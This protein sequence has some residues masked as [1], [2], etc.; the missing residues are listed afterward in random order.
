MESAEFKWE[1]DEF[2]DTFFQEVDKLEELAILTQHHHHHP[3]PPKP[4]SSSA[5]FHQLP[6][7]PPPIIS[8]TSFANNNGGS[9]VIDVSYSPPRELSQRFQP[10]LDTANSNS[11]NTQEQFEIDRL[12]SEL[13]RVS[14]QLSDL[15]E[16]CSE[17][18]RDRDKKKQ[19]KCVSSNVEASIRNAGAPVLDLPRSGSA[20]RCENA[21]AG[22]AASSSERK[23]VA[24]QTERIDESVSP[25]TNTATS[26]LLAVWSSGSSHISRRN[27][28]A[29][30]LE[31]C[32]SDFCFLF[33]CLDPNMPFKIEGGRLN[34][35]GVPGSVQGLHS[36]KAARMSH[37]Y[38]VLMKLSN[39]LAHVDALVEALLDLCSLE[40]VFAYS[41][42]CFGSSAE[43]G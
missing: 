8:G 5:A 38:S 22:P 27:F 3:H 32:A 7:P 28:I 24:I 4:S 37:L 40:N 12:K 2:D 15:K 33:G 1:D 18:R 34:L 35:V 29:K 31:T 43:H 10:P 20:L 17:L 36:A 41:A 6:P 21:G 9:T 23:S 13:S 19:P 42:C 16:E 30:L 14:K 11:S 26:K 25:N 39:D